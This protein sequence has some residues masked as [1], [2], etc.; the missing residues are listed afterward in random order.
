MIQLHKFDNAID[1]ESCYVYNGS[2]KNQFI[3]IKALSSPVF[4]N[5][6]KFVYCK[7][8]LEFILRCAQNT[9]KLCQLQLRL[10]GVC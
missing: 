7:K 6:Q 4:I 8:Y 1:I 9:F 2:S 3:H 5:S 10:I